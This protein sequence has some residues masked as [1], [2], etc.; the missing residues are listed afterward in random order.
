MNKTYINLKAIEN[1]KWFTWEK[2][3]KNYLVVP[4]SDEKAASTGTL[5]WAFVYNNQE[6]F[7]EKMAGKRV[8]A[9]RI[10]SI[11]EFSKEGKTWLWGMMF[12]NE[13]K[14]AYFVNLYDNEMRTPD[15]DFDK[16]L[17]LTETERREKP[18]DSN[19]AEKLF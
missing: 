11:K 13:N 1:Q 8:D 3:S 17:V 2:D 19:S 5:F 12:D 6:T 18:T 9:D 16:L 7:N 15:K 10:A 14:K 4:A